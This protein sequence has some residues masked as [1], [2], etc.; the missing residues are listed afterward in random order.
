MSQRGP[1]RETSKPLR[2]L[3]LGGTRAPTHCTFAADLCAS[4]GPGGRVRSSTSALGN[5][6]IPLPVGALAVEV[7][8]TKSGRVRGFPPLPAR[9]PGPL[10]IAVSGTKPAADLLGER[11]L[12]HPPRR[13]PIAMGPQHRCGV[14]PG[15]RK[16]PELCRRGSSPGGAGRPRPHRG[17]LDHQLPRCPCGASPTARITHRGRVALQPGPRRN[18]FSLLDHVG[19]WGCRI[20]NEDPSR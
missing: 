13:A 18:R 20:V 6:T 10:V 12:E 2:G 7:T 9:P 8:A 5:S 15:P 16:F 4:L 3:R 17:R 14:P 19:P 11:D 1:G